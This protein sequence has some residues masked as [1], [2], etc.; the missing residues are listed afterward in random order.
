MANRATKVA[1]VWGSGAMPELDFRMDGVEI[2]RHAAA[3]MLNFKLRLSAGGARIRNVMLHTQIR[4]EPARRDYAAGEQARLGELFGAPADWSRTLQ[5]LLWTHIDLTVAPFAGECVVDL[6]VPCSYDFNLGATKYFHGLAEGEV[7]LL[8][9]FSGSI[10]YDNAQGV[11]QLDPIAWS[12]EARY[13]LP[14]AVW[15]E[16]MARYYPG[17]V[18]LRLSREVF[19]RLHG[20]KRAHGFASW[21][22]ALADLLDAR[23]EHAAAEHTREDA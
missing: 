18:P 10:F 1:A 17:T 22:G 12:K 3:P 15:R 19:D 8:L 6:P 13:R 11:L 21:E 5:G 14:V 16:L 20:Y 7:P 4:I 2:E 9:L 23:A